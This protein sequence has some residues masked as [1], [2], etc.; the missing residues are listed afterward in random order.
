MAH[1]GQLHL[2]PLRSSSVRGRCRA[3]SVGHEFPIEGRIWPCVVWL[4]WFPGGL[5]SSRLDG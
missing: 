2:R 4:D 1:A 5:H 3:Y